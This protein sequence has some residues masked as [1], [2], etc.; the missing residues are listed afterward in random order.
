VRGDAF[1]AAERYV[2]NAGGGEVRIYDQGGALVQR[3]AVGTA[4]RHETGSVA[5]AA[6]GQ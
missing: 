6:A 3:Y 5:R 1:A 4:A 2:R